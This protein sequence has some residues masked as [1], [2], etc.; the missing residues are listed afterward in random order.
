MGNEIAEFLMGNCYVIIYGIA[1]ILSV[2]KY[3]YYFDTPLKTLPII[4][5]YVLLTEILGFLIR[6]FE[7]IQ[8]VFENGYSHYNHLIYNILD[9]IFFLY[10][11]I[12]Y[13]KSIT[14]KRTKNIIRKGIL[15]IIVIA[16]LNP[17]FEEFI[18][19]PQL[20]VIIFGSILLVFCSLSYLK[21]VMSK[22]IKYSNYHKL[23]KC[24]SLGLLLFYP[25]YPFI[26]GIGQYNEDL[27]WKLHLREVLLV[28]II[29]MYALFSIGFI[30]LKKIQ[31][32]K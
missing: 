28:L 29:I 12:I 16:L 6:D 14:E 26:I 17:F 4:I 20:G 8:V 32:L 11:F 13:K 18:L 30:K 10:F 25:F 27:Y 1:L 24:I 5:G 21:E 23:M 9:T 3:R 15:V 22:P 31:F 2:L 19:F 7:D